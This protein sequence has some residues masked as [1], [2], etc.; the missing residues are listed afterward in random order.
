[1]FTQALIIPDFIIV[2]SSETHTKETANEN[3]DAEKDTDLEGCVFALAERW[4]VL[5]AWIEGRWNTL[6]EV[7]PL[8]AKFN[9]DKNGLNGWLDAVEKAL[10]IMERS[11]T[12]D[13][14]QLRQQAKDIGVSYTHYNSSLN[15]MS[16]AW[17]TNAPT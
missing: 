5:C 10:R 1:M 17:R 7:A 6:S 4:Y 3:A 11:P 16:A 8:Y 14:E 2:P 12:K 9:E 13:E 15:T